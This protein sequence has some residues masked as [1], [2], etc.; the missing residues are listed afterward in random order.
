MRK[1]FFLLFVLLIGLSLGLTKD[2]HAESKV[3]FE[4]PDSVQF[5]AL[6]VKYDSTLVS[7][8]DGVVVVLVHFDASIVSPETVRSTCV[9]CNSPPSIEQSKNTLYT[10]AGTSSEFQRPHRKM[11]LEISNYEL[12][13]FAPKSR[14][15]H[16]A[17]GSIQTNQMIGRSSLSAS[18]R[19]V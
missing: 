11:E 17:K 6:V 2:S 10:K 14:I 13:N 4:R 19:S 7:V 3:L 8:A 12:S 1:S 18:W 16:T 5:D 9:D 15:L